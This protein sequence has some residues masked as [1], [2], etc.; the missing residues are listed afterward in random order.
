MQFCWFKE[1]TH[2]LYLGDGYIFYTKFFTQ[3]ALETFSGLGIMA[4]PPLGGV[5]YEVYDLYIKYL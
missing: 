5:L 3:G 1:K 2:K 4:G